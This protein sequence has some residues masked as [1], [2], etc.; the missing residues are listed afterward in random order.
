V[1]NEILYEH[2]VLRHRFIAEL[3]GECAVI[4]YAPYKVDIAFIHTFVPVDLRGR[5]IASVLAI[6]ALQYAREKHVKIMLI[7]PFMARY[8]K[9]NPEYQDLVDLRYTDRAGR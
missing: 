7:C 3:A 2:D 9:E 5:G 8:V 4:Q 1:I 6:N